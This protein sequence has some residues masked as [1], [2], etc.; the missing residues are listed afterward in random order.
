MS[1]CGAQPYAGLSSAGMDAAVPTAGSARGGLS[2]ALRPLTLGN[3]AKAYCLDA[4]RALAVERESLRI[5]DLGAGDARNFVALL[6]EF[7]CPKRHQ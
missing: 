4:I 2:T 6:R 7:P 3:A 5:V 1:R